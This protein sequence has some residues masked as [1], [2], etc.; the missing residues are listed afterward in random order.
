[1]QK[2]DFAGHCPKYEV[3]R[4]SMALCTCIQFIPGLNIQKHY[5]MAGIILLDNIIAKHTS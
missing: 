1:M 3:H 5:D 4:I 2:G